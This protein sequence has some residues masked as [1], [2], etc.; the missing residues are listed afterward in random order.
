MRETKLKM[1]KMIPFFIL[2]V[3][4]VSMITNFS[5]ADTNPN[6][7]TNFCQG[8]ISQTAAE[9]ATSGISGILEISFVIIGVMLIAIALAFT[10]GYSFKIEKMIS[11]SKMEFGEII[12]TLIIITVFVGAAGATPLISAS[13]QQTN[14]IFVNDCTYLAGSSVYVFKV[15]LV[16]FL[17]RS[18]GLELLTNLEINLNPLAFGISFSPLTAYGLVQTGLG[19]FTGFAEMLAGIFLGLIVFLGVIYVLFPLFL[20][21]GIV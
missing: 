18:F 14:N 15:M 3:L 7:Y 17:P 1:K 2:G 13:P 21:L 5:F 20:Y 19:I 4:L 11:F 10:I 12:T 6:P 16:D 9:T 8:A